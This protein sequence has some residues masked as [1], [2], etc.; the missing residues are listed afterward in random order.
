MTSMTLGK[1]FII[2][3][4]LLLCPNR[5]KQG[6]IDGPQNDLQKSKESQVHKQIGTVQES[7]GGRGR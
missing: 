6:K 2:F 5:S 7:P 3:I 4:Q 1:H